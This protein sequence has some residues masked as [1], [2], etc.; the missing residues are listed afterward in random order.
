MPFVQRI[1][2]PIRLGRQ[3]VEEEYRFDL[4]IISNRK[5]IGALRQIGS[6]ASRADEIVAEIAKECEEVIKRT[7]RLSDRIRHA[8]QLTKQLN[9]KAVTVRK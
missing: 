6:L 3:P 4:D 5:L 2:E 9:A 8:D 1:V 7:N